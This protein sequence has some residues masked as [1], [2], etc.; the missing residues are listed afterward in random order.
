MID[1]KNSP[2]TLKYSRKLTDL[3]GELKTSPPVTSRQYENTTRL[4]AVS[5]DFFSRLGMTNAATGRHSPESV[6]LESGHQTNFMPHCGMWKKAYL[7]S[8]V[9]QKIIESGGESIPFFGFADQNL[10]TAKYLYRNH[11]PA[12]NNNGSEPIGFKIDEK[13]RFRTFR[14]LEKPEEPVW[15]KEMDRI[16]QLYHGNARKLPDRPIFFSTALDTLL[17]I[18]WKSYDRADNFAEL[19]AF[20]FARICHDVLG[21]DLKFFM[22]SDIQRE[23][24]FLEESIQL[25]AHLR[26]Y[27]QTYNTI[28]QEK[29]L[30]IPV[31]TP[32]HVPFWYHCTCGSKIELFIDDTFTANGVCPFCKEEYGLF[33]GK[34]FENL[35]QFFDRMDFTAVS[36]NI[37]V[38]LGI[39]NA[40]FIPGA[41][42]SLQYGAISDGIAKAFAFHQPLTLSWR[43]SD[44]YLGL[45]HTIVLKDLLKAAGCITGDLPGDAL[46]EKIAGRIRAISAEI[47]CA[48][49]GN[50]D[51]KTQKSMKNNLR[52]F[53]NLVESAEKIFSL[54]PSALDVLVN[55]D[56]E[57]IPPLWDEACQRALVS[58]E[59]GL[60]QIEEDILYPN[61]LLRDLVPG[62][63]PTLYRSIRQLEVSNGKKNTDCQPSH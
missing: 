51:K 8:W 26:S 2:G 54:T 48:E 5:G 47:A 30:K 4:I 50:H 44:Y 38:S 14:S 21:F 15:Q 23:K 31:V 49:T 6:V 7:L 24:L 3:V 40:L 58:T 20:I 41:G 61:A 25:L 62:A 12:L 27:N 1:L 59:G 17:E 32:E 36:R 45:V 28:I 10:S 22:Y 19:N 34:N 43:S 35:G 18:L 9:H 57:G 11:V 53:L 55:N 13:C 63:L 29:N 37:V 46:G 39:G 42:G 56:P 33:F 60:N 52:Q 16:K